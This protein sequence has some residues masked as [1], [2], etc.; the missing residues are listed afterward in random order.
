[1][2]TTMAAKSRNEATKAIKMIWGDSNVLEKLDGVMRNK[3]IAEKM[4]T[5][6]YDYSW[7]QCK[8]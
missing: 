6:G 5:Q 7:K 2:Q 1:M 3:D 4:C 8:T